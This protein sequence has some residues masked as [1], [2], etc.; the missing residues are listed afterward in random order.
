MASQPTRTT[1]EPSAQEKA[2]PARSLWRDG[3]FLKLWGGQSLSLIGSQVTIIAMPLVA[4]QLLNANAEQMG[5]LG[6]LGRLPFVLFLF[7]GVF[8]DRFRRRPTMI[9]TDLGRALAIGLIPALFF[10]DMLTIYWLYGIVLVA[11]VLGVF[12]EVANQAFLPSLLGRDRVPEG[13]ARFQISQS[14]AQVSG[15]S[16]AGVLIAFLSAASVMLIDAVSYVVGAVA[17]AL[18]R[19]PEPAPSGSGKPPPIFT[20]MREGL[21]WVWTQPVI[22]PL[23]VS[24][25]CYMTFTAGIQAL[26]VF[27]LDEQLH[28]ATSLIG[29][30]LAFLG[31][32]AV[33]GSLLSLT[34]LRRVG[35]GPSAFWATVGGNAAFLLIP[36]A[37]GPT[38]LTVGLLAAAQLLIGMSGPMAQVGMASL[39]MVLTPDNM[40]GRVVGSFRG[41]SLGLAPLGALVAGVLS[42]GIG[43]RLTLLIFAIGVLTPIAVMALSPLPRLKELPEPAHETNAG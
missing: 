38:W 18:I 40:Q 31:V 8:A 7:A 30:T 22:R 12:F 3:D 28:L 20:A 17:S 24:T 27:Y 23:L 4:V 36:L 19:K 9:V 34:V 26:Y 43:L 42:E 1:D 39:R 21:R 41:I 29:L 25:A 2:A 33:L 15:P 37:G 35:P 32:G 13:N 14:V 5:V 10:A 16:V 11:G 6:A